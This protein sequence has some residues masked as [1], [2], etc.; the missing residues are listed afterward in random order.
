MRMSATLTFLFTLRA[1]ASHSLQTW[2]EEFVD[3]MQ[4]QPF[5]MSGNRPKVQD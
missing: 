5:L 3:S 2:Q 1:V 4:G